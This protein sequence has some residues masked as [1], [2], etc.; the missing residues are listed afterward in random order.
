MY[1]TIEATNLIIMLITSITNLSKYSLDRNHNNM[2]EF[3]YYI[4]TAMK[5][6]SRRA[7]LDSLWFLT[8][9]KKAFKI[10]SL[11]ASIKNKYSNYIKII[12]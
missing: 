6:P 1:F 7:N 4:G 9:L 12:C 3:M 5:Y 8:I 11:T 2:L 10:N